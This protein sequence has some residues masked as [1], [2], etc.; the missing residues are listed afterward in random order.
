MACHSRNF[1]CWKSPESEQFFVCD[2]Q[3]RSV[4]TGTLLVLL[5]ENAIKFTFF[6]ALEAHEVLQ[7]LF[8]IEIESCESY[9]F[10]RFSQFSDLVDDRILGEKTY[11]RCLKN[12]N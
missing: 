12:Q 3:T 8:D 9:F 5:I 7:S 4:S 10:A 6:A 1:S 2:A 11:H